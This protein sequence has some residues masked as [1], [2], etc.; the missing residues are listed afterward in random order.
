MMIAEGFPRRFAL[1][2]LL[3]LAMLVSAV[4]ITLSTSRVKPKEGLIFYLRP[5]LSHKQFVN[6]LADKNIVSSTIFK[7]FVELQSQVQ[8][9][10]GEY[11]LPEGAS[12]WQIWRQV[13]TGT[14]HYYRSFTIIPGWS[15]AQLRLE[16]A[17]TES[18][19]QLTK[20]QPEE[21]IMDR[22][23]GSYQQAEGV[24][25]PET[26]L[27]T[28]GIADLVI[29]KRAYDLMQLRLQEAWATKDSGL[30]YQNAYQAL[31]A[32]SLIEK[33]AYLDTERPL[34]ASVLINRLRKGMLLQFD[35]TVIYGL[36]ERY[37]GHITKADL[38]DPNLYNTY[39]HKGLPPTPIAMP[40][41]DSIYAALHPAKTNYLYFVAKGD[42]S[43]QF[44]TT[45][46]AHLAAV[47]FANKKAKVVKPQE[48]Y[49]NRKIINQRLDKILA[50]K[51]VGIG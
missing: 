14:G 1:L 40:S 15:F 27:Y 16:L 38:M 49:F 34:I 37:Q 45:L 47:N 5:G 35:P 44:S 28:R 20:D 51:R 25:F 46:A 31:V 9:K 22:L 33:E 42:H 24:F 19:R 17:K 11:L 43:H 29:L 39:I 7:I 30:P 3:G 36:K 23:G 4:F 10:T 18:L 50:K 13:T 48:S 6:E 21:V 32:A 12:A 2:V 26:Y 8:L 41:Y